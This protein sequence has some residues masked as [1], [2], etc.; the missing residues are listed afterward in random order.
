MYRTLLAFALLMAAC[1]PL[2]HPFADDHPPANSPILAPPDS[3]G[4]IV[5]PVTG[6]PAAAAPQMA[7]AM[8]SA[9]QTLDVPASTTDRNRASFQ[10]TGVAREDRAGRRVTVDWELRSAAGA[11][12]GRHATMI[13]GL[14]AARD[15]ASAAARDAAPA[16]ARMISGEAPLPVAVADPVVSFRGVTGSPGDGAHALERAIRD[17]LGRS[18]IS[19][20]ARTGAPSIAQIA[21]AVSLSP[22]NAGKQQVK[23]VW[24]VT[25]PDGS[26]IGQ[27]KQENAV[28][29][30]SLDGAWGEV[31]YAVAAAAGPGIASIVGRVA[32]AAAH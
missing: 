32:P 23:I 2:P 7:E 6:T 25:R 19:D 21:A 4:I 24:R 16:I 1:Q 3:A 9:L 14:P 8:A 12:V 5:L 17:P 15:L 20:A 22:P 29:A 13:A 31:A 27:V 28:P 11:I 26:E 18:H 10:L 30:G